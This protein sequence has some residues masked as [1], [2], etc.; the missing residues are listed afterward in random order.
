MR[1][2]RYPAHTSNALLVITTLLFSTVYSAPEVPMGLCINDTNCSNASHNSPGLF[3]GTNLKFYPGIILWTFEN[4][5][6]ETIESRWQAL[7]TSTPN[8]KASYRPA[9]IYGGVT[10][11]LNWSRFYKDSKV[12]PQAP[13]NHKDPAYDWSK[14]DAIFNINAVQNE[15]ALVVIKIADIGNGRPPK[16]LLNIPYDGAF[17]AQQYDKTQPPVTLTPKYYRYEG[18]DSR[19]NAN[20]N[21][22]L[23]IVEE[24]VYFYQALH[25]HI[26]D[27]GNMD[28]VMF[29]HLDEVFVNSA[30][31]PNDYN[32]AAF[33]HGTGVRN[34]KVAKIWAASQIAVHQSSLVGPFA[35]TLWQY[36]DNPPLGLTFP[37]MKMSGTNNISGAS[38]FSNMTGTY[39]KDIRPLSQ[40]V[41]ANGLRSHTYFAPDIPNPWGYSGVSVPQTMSHVLWALSGSPKG[42]NKDSG[43]GQNGTDPPGVMPVHNI[44]VSWSMTWHEHNPSLS[45]WHEALDTFGPPGTF[46]FPYLP[47]GFQP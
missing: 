10:A 5:S 33:Q 18:P 3:P 42:E 44:F 6:P 17:Y 31:L 45:E 1:G 36:M 35:E 24:L 25:D 16:W 39:Q 22:S 30:I 7:F 23:P 19:G 2:S 12:R 9:G 13:S 14:I 32:S 46:A 43:L 34:N 26:K 4:D 29:V 15:G 20:A 40:A 47:E 8:R 11:K 37:D 28:K 41:E 38:R 27:T 21:D